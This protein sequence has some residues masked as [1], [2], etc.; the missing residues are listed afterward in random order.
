MELRKVVSRDALAGLIALL[1]WTCQAQTPKRVA[2]P[3]PTSELAL[4]SAN[5]AS[6]EPFGRDAIEITLLKDQIAMAKGYQSDMVT[7]T[8]A[9][10]G[11]LVAVGLGVAALNIWNNQRTRLALKG[12]IDALNEQFRREIS[13]NVATINKQRE[14]L[15]VVSFGLAQSLVIIACPSDRERKLSPPTTKLKHQTATTA[16][17]LL[18]GTEHSQ[19]E[20]AAV[21][22]PWVKWSLSTFWL[23]FRH[24]LWTQCALADGEMQQQQD[25]SGNVNPTV[26]EQIAFAARTTARVTARELLVASN[27]PTPPDVAAAIILLARMQAEIAALYPELKD[28]LAASCTDWIP[29]LLHLEKHLD[30]SDPGPWYD[31]AY[32]LR[33]PAAVWG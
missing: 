2:P 30:L 8:W 33:G 12:D 26:G 28:G 14:D 21:L 23:G 22:E 10:L 32:E 6:S 27:Q 4:R 17:L 11:T 3:T 9:M 1:C 31:L 16:R 13:S 20:I 19:A 25:R 7:A 5:V 18:S 15:R 29:R 24:R